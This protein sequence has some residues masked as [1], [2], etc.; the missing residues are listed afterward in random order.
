MTTMTSTPTDGSRPR[1]PELTGTG[2][3][4]QRIQ[5]NLSKCRA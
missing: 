3:L 2:L 1:L 4:L 5:G